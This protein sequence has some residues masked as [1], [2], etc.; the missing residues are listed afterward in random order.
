MDD[1]NQPPVSEAVSPYFFVLGRGG[2]AQG[3][4]LSAALTAV[5]LAV[6]PDCG[7][8]GVFLLTA[9]LL[10]IFVPLKRVLP[11]RLW[12]VS[13]FFLLAVSL[14]LFPE[15]WLGVADT[16]K[17]VLKGVSEIIPG[18][19]DPVR[20]S[21]DPQSTFFWILLLAFSI[22][23][24]LYSLGSP[25]SSRQVRNLALLAALGCSIYAVVAIVSWTTGWHYPFSVGDP[26]LQPAFGFFP[27]RNHTA[28]FL[29][30]GSIL[31][32]GLMRSEINDG[33]LLVA[34]VAASAFVLLSG[35]LLF[36]SIS[37]GGLLFLVLGV[38]LWM[39]GL[40][41][42]RS[43]SLLAFGGVLALIMAMLFL[44]SG[45]M[46][47]ERL[48]GNEGQGRQISS[49]SLAPGVVSEKGAK[50]KPPFHARL[51]IARDTLSMIAAHPVSGT[52]LGTYAVMYPFYADKSLREQTWA[53]HAESD[54]LTLCAEGGIPA[55]FLAFAGVGILCAGIPR[56]AVLSGKEWPVR[57]AFLAAF[58]VELLHG[59]V[60]VPLHRPE[61]GWWIMLLG[62][63]GFSGSIG[64]AKSSPA[65][66][67]LQRG[68]FLTGGL[69]MIFTGG[70]L[71][72]SGWG[73]GRPLSPFASQEERAKILSL[74]LKGDAVSLQQSFSECKK[75]ISDH[76]LEHL[77][78]YQLALL[79]L[80]M[81]HNDA[82]AESLFEIERGLSPNDPSFVFEQGKVLAERD[83]DAAVGIWQEALRRQLVLDRRPSASTPRS[84]D[85]FA[86]MITT[87]QGHPALFAQLP[88]L[89]SVSP[90]LRMLW[91]ERPECDPEL[92]AAALRDSSFM[93]ELEPR[94]Q[95]G[96]IELWR[97]H[98]G[99]R[100]EIEVF[101]L[102][103]PEYARV[104][105][106]TKAALLADSGKA[107]EACEYLAATFHLKIS[108]AEVPLIQTAGQDVPEDPLVAARYYLERG[109]NVAARRLL[110]EAQNSKIKEE[111]PGEASFL[112]ALLEMRAENWNAALPD[113]L[114]FLR[115]TG[116]P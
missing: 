55:M 42:Y 87:A 1:V 106:A 85:L 84:P 52:G 73:W 54:W 79:T 37:R 64:F 3:L 32:L 63:I 7:G 27:N 58:F 62:G 5:F 6:G 91:Y 105:F 56:M 57:W 28:G 69:A 59:F 15:K 51:A 13:C 116:Q 75:A 97:Q 39:C 11:G 9:G 76:P 70:L 93:N 16:W 80:E 82:R 95:G 103:H 72:C 114:N 23:I 31:A 78:Y 43:R 8:M 12:V 90:E 99:Q 48:R 88:S 4:L 14:A 47:M 60:D 115:A 61:L 109:N 66:L 20:I 100:N 45:N 38:L 71:I 30:T 24:A 2:L 83:P 26:W 77:L 50:K 107:K 29:L 98:H 92:I 74:F 18:L 35:S 53:L 104:A 112:G 19:S 21:A 101:L 44:H 40:G 67:A 46:L 81:D 22:L 33:R 113:L 94:Q 102:Q 10:L 89:S 86:A 36:F 34:L 111:Y 25:L 65:V 49:Q 68:V 110:T 96:L 108:E 41:K 17:I